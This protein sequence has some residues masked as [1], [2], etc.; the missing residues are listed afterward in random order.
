MAFANDMNAIEQ[1]TRYVKYI[2]TY[3]E[4]AIKH[5]GLIDNEDNTKYMVVSKNTRRRVRQNLTINDRNFE[6]AEETEAATRILAENSSF[7]AAQYLF[8]PKLLKRHKNIN[9]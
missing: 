9:I 2:F 7:Y 5:M 3:F 1:S 8:K 4:N 6:I